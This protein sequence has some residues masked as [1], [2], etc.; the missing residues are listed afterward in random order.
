MTGTDVLG[1]YVYGI[2]L[3]DLPT[4]RKAPLVGTKPVPMHEGVNYKL[5]DEIMEFIEAHPET[6]H[7]A[8]WF[9]HLDP[10]TGDS[11]WHVTIEEVSERNSCGT[12]FCFAG[13]VALHEGF[14]SPPLDSNESWERTIDGERWPEH[15]DTFAMN[16]LGITTAQADALF[17]GDNTMTDLRN[18]VTA[19]HVDPDLHSWELREFANDFEDA[20]ASQDE[21]KD[22]FKEQEVA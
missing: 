11:K 5:L 2:P 3:Q 14:P 18:M 22:Y 15:V 16:R 19:L 6:W 10:E 13:H 9:Q 7:Q 21:V 1:T 20:L 12:S 4:Y 17:D 8:S